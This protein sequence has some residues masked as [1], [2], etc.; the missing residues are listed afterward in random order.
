[1]IW[2][3]LKIVT[4]NI[5]RQKFYAFINI[6][7]LTIGVI[8]SLLIVLYVID[9]FSYDKF[10][11]DAGLI[12][13]V[14]LTGRM[15][16]QEFNSV[17]TSAPLA[18]GIVQ[19]IPEVDKACRIAPWK[20]VI[21]KNQEDDF[22]EKSVLLADSNFFDFFSFRL[23]EGEMNSVLSKP[24]SLVLTESAANKIFGYKGPG[25]PTPVGKTL[26]FGI[27]KWVCTVTGIAK[28][29][30]SNSHFHFSMILSM[31]SWDYSRSPIW[32]SNSLIT[33]VRL[34]GKADK[35]HIESGLS[36]LVKKNIGPQAQTYLGISF[37]DFLKQ[38]GAY[39]Y[40]LQPLLKI[41]FSPDPD[42]HLEPGGN[43]NTIYLLIGIAIFIIVIACINFMNLSTARFSGRAK[44]VGIR[45]SLG[46]STGSLRSQFLLES[47]MYILFA[48]IFAH[49]MMALILPGFNNQSGKLLSIISLSNVYYL[50]AVMSLIF[51]V[52]I[53][54]G[55]YPAF[56][57]TSFSPVEV[58]R[59]T[60]RAGMKSKNMRRILVI[61]Q[62]TMST[63]LIIC[64]LLVSKQLQFLKNKDK[65]FDNQNLIVIRN[66]GSL[67]AGKTSFKEELLK[68]PEV[69]TASICDM[70]PPDAGKH[71][72]IFRPK[73]EDDQ[74]RGCNYCIV[75]EDMVETLKLSMADGRFFSKDFPSDSRAVVI[76]EAAA[77]SFGWGNPIG[78]KI[79]TF[80]K[81]NGEDEREVI[82]VVKDYNYQTL[83]E[84]IT[85]LLIFPGEEGNNMVVRLSNGDVK[86]MTELIKDK[87]EAFPSKGYFDYSFIA[88][89]FFDKFRKEQQL[90]RLFI[91]FTILAIFVASLGLLGLST[92]SAEQRSKETGIRKAMGASSIT[93]VRIISLEYLNLVLISFIIAVPL[94]YLIISWWLKNFAYKTNIG[95]FSFISGGIIAVLVAVLSVGYQ[96]VKTA[97]RNPVISLKY[98]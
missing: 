70:V 75:D 17:Y 49:I 59:G 21:I 92:F 72:D 36:E 67:G 22:M 1:M 12:S 28:D 50:V 43:I 20:D 74:K 87:W 68:M 30:P 24:R 8:T 10:H 73:G 33:Y 48:V 83:N 95:M 26:E 32:V 62:F 9:E 63:G 16:G 57:L 37:D 54:A 6:A 93:V 38:G 84:E 91:V 52:G 34:N 15:S 85:P 47:V 77:K 27:E 23:I 88:D 25:D 86:R 46:G 55:S 79:Q 82:G 66:I 45:K 31:Q 18:S 94:S 4:R 69:I 51:I 42:L 11:K 5:K 65:G 39:G 98:E 44:E 81:E 53:L 56:Y 35:S 13:R 80:W 60:I 61:F 89:D 58:L 40:Y 96:S 7:G 76:N 97:F 78:K 2:N 19:D 29:P 3:Y 90:G 14:N 64:T 71:S 41:H